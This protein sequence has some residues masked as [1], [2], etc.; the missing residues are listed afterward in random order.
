MTNAHRRLRYTIFMEKFLP[1]PPEE[2]IK[3]KESGIAKKVMLGAAL[4]GAAGGL[5]ACKEDGESGAQAGDTGQPQ[6]ESVEHG[7]EKQAQ[8]FINQISKMSVGI[9]DARG[10]SGLLVD[11]DA[12]FGVFTNGL[13][14]DN[15]LENRTKAAKFLLSELPEQAG[16]QSEGLLALSIL[17]DRYD[18]TGGQVEALDDFRGQMSGSDDTEVAPGRGSKQGGE[19]RQN[20]ML[21]N[22]NW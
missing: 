9:D 19:T 17:L 10:R 11:V 16:G 12:K 15:T 7:L 4:A 5:S 20:P 13:F 18:L 21:N 2:T 8:D 1:Q 3:Q 6:V 22:D 14:G